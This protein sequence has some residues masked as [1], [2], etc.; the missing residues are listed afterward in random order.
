MVSS[1]PMRKL[2]TLSL[3]LT[4]VASS[5]HAGPVDP[6][7]VFYSATYPGVVSAQDINAPY[8]MLLNVSSTTI[9]GALAYDPVNQIV[10]G[11]FCCTAQTTVNALDATTL[12]P[13]PSRNFPITTGGSSTM[14]LDVSHRLL[15]VF[16][17]VSLKLTGYSI[18]INNYGAS[19][20]STTLSQVYKL[21]AITDIGDMIAVDEVGK[22]LLVTG[23][24]GGA[25][26][27][28]DVSAVTSA[29]GTIG[30]VTATGQNA[31]MTGNSGGAVAVDQQ[32]RRY[33]T[34]TA[35]G[36]V[37]AFSADS[38][39][40]LIK[41]YAIAG[42]GSDDCG[43]FYDVRTDTIYVG[44]AGGANPV[45][46]NLTSGVVTA[47]ASVGAGQVP[48]LSFTGAIA[49]PTP[50]DPTKVFYAASWS[51]SFGTVTAQDL[52]APYAVIRSTQSATINGSLGYD[53]ITKTLYGGFCCTS[54]NIIAALDATTL[55]PVTAKNLTITHSG[56][57][58][59]KVDASSR[60]VWVF[61]TVSLKLSAISID[62]NNYGQT[63]ASTTL[64]SVYKLG[65][66]TDIGDMLSIDEQAHR[67]VVTGGDGGLIYIVDVSSVTSTGGTIGAVTST[68]QSA[69]MNG[70]SGGAVAVDEKGR[71]YFTIPATGTVR[72]F[73]ADSPFSKIQD[74]TVAGMAGNDCGL[75]YDLR[76]DTLYVGRGGGG[77]PIGINLT[78][79]VQT[80]FAGIGAGQL[81]GISYSGAI[82]GTP[83]PPPDM[84]MPDATVLPDLTVI[85][86]LAK[87]DLAL[88]DLTMSTPDLGTI[89]KADCTNKA[90]G[91]GDGCGGICGGDACFAPPD[92][93]TFDLA[94]SDLA[95]ND[96]ATSPDMAFP[97]FEP[98]T[99]ADEF[100]VV[101]DMTKPTGS[102]DLSVGGTG[103]SPGGCGC[104]VAG[105]AHDQTPLALAIFTLGIAFAVRRRARRS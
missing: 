13:V 1:A 94:M 97:G 100:G 21:G 58:S 23:G 63:V 47:F 30:A 69:R 79:G 54:Q 50:I 66:V 105:R 88:P 6:N 61:D 68:G 93:E 77:V 65:A 82:E 56:S 48:G 90:C 87:P 71:R 31:R 3:V 98:P 14:K 39:Y 103:A 89:C 25:V 10:Y 96:L 83:P 59:S 104:H 53:P 52:N 86:D 80:A 37:R 26:Y 18:D 45:G 67:L 62:T 27:V 73:G 34:I 12:Q 85:P 75:F 29:G 57:L 44:R 72:A 40:G 84:F 8:T 28:V 102:P 4:L 81:V 60:L 20:A 55:S 7:K 70:N 17:T 91:S 16:D 36:T 32:G 51:S 99:P 42:M 76:N 92:F 41:D 64:S 2:P 35:T 5:A 24:D 49:P 11:G 95:T 38:P 46:L 74:Y 15:W 22:R 9:N 19:V 33:F 43:L 78:S 101:A